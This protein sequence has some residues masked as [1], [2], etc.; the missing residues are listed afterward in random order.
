MWYAFYPEW[1]AKDP[2]LQL[3]RWE[4]RFAEIAARYGRRI[5]NWDVINEVLSWAPGRPVMMPESHVE[6]VFRLAEKYFPKGT[7][8]NYNEQPC[9]SW[10]STS[11]M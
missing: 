6:A 5:H 2:Q 10:S 8:L 7:V 11:W 1:V 9:P 3:E 4:Q